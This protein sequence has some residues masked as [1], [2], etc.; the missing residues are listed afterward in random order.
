ML[1]F[2]LST[3]LSFKSDWN[4]IL[5]GNEKDFSLGKAHTQEN[6]INIV[7]H[8]NTKSTS[9]I[10]LFKQSTENKRNLCKFY[11][12]KITKQK[13]YETPYKQNW[14]KLFC[15]FFVHFPKDSFCFQCHFTNR[16]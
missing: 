16:I 1:I 13:L 12:W 5:H 2:K 4:Q 10:H 6:A 9:P 15:N 3:V 14:Y 8:S 11:V 7:E